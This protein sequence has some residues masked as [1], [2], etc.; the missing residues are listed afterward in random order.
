MPPFKGVHQD[1]QF[2]ALKIDSV[3]AN[4]KGNVQGLNCLD[5]AG[6]IRPAGSGWIQAPLDVNG[7]ESCNFYKNKSAAGGIN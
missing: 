3:K 1:P 2:F 7:K 6:W 4:L 5:P